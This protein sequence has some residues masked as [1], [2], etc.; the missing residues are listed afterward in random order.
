MTGTSI[1]LTS[2][3]SNTQKLVFFPNTDYGQTYCERTMAIG[4]MNIPLGDPQYGFD[5]IWGAEVPQRTLTGSDGMLGSIST[6]VESRGYFITPK[7]VSPNITDKFN[8]VT[9]KFSP[10]K[11]ELDKIIIKYRT[12]D[13]MKE[14]MDLSG[15]TGT[16]TSTTTFTSTET[17]L[18][19]TVIGD[20]VEIVKGAGGGLIAHITDI[21]SHILLIL[22]KV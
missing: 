10:M 18:A 13:D 11:S 22:S 6:E 2:N 3:G 17:N 9:L 14:T 12:V 7:I 8:L 5:L 1:T 19:D 15:W 4:L 20:E 16:W 21:S